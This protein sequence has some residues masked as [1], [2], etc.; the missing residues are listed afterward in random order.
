MDHFKRNL[1]YNGMSG[2]ISIAQLYR[3]YA[4]Y[5]GFN[6]TSLLISAEKCPQFELICTPGWSDNML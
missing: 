2:S 1:C 5:N 3:L 4:S 6:I